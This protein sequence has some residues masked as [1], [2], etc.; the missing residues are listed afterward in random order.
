MNGRP[1]MEVDGATLTL[2]SQQTHQMLGGAP[3]SSYLFRRTSPAAHLT[4]GVIAAS[5][6][7]Q[8]P[9]PRRGLLPLVCRA[10]GQ[11]PQACLHFCMP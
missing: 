7:R 9:L 11:A 3:V 8:Q 2:L 1:G 4:P 10:P 5:P 6:V